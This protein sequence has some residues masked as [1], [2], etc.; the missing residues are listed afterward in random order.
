MIVGN[1]DA[2][3]G[4]ESLIQA[5]EQL[6]AAED[7]ILDTRLTPQEKIEQAQI[8]AAA[9]AEAWVKEK[10][11]LEAKEAAEAKE[12]SEAELKTNEKSSKEGKSE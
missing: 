11:R 12:R 9:K 3:T 4:L 7:A 2:I 8:R 1:P 10:A 6:A 5:A